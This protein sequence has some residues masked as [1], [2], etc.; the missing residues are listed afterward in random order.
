VI[1]TGAKTLTLVASRQLA[2]G[3]FITVAYTTDPTKFM[4]GQVTNYDV[5][6]KIMSFNSLVTG[7]SGTFAVWTVG[8]SGSRGTQ[9]D[10]VPVIVS[11]DANK[12]MVVNSGETQ[13]VHTDIN[14]LLDWQSISLLNSK[15]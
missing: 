7:G 9:G 1:G 13:H 12:V 8:V 2:V 4:W 14:D 15:Y 3:D 10:G 6:T 5:N 11:G